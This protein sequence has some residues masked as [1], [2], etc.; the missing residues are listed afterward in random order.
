VLLASLLASLLALSAA[1][2]PARADELLDYLESRGLD[3]LAAMR[4]EDLAARHLVP[5]LAKLGMLIGG[6]GEFGARFFA[7][8]L[9]LAATLAVWRLMRGLFDAQIA[10]W[11]VV[12]VNVL[13]AFNLAAVTLT[14]A[15]V[16]LA[17]VPTAALCLRIA[18]LHAHPLHWAWWAAAACVLGAVMTQPPAFGMMLAVTMVEYDDEDEN[19]ESD[20][21]AGDDAGDCYGY[22]N[23]DG[24]D[25]EK[26]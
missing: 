1:T 7:P 25:G 19:N 13:P 4:L 10:G 26:W 12:I 23:D 15:T 24:E 3:S 2:S 17:L 14:P 16:M 22:D 21:D 6:E 5:L 11:A 9:A 8:L 20:D 18:L